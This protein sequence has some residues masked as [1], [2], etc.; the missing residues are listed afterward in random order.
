L[1]EAR[2]LL[3]IL[4]KFPGYTLSALLQEDVR[5]LRLLHIEALGTPDPDEGG[6]DAWPETT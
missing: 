6:D 3:R 2:W 4:R 5:L 1:I